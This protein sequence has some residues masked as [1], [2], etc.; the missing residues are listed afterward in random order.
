[1]YVAAKLLKAGYSIAYAADA[2]VYHSHAYTITQEIKR[3]FDMGVFHANQPWLKNEFGGA[4]N[5]GMKFISS[6]IR[7]LWQY[8][9]WRIPEVLLRTVLKYVAFRLGLVEA[10]IPL[11]IKRKLSMNPGYFKTR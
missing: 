3:Y 6:E 10:H 11:G 8:A 1:M 9:S 2:C 5:E 4:E 7:H